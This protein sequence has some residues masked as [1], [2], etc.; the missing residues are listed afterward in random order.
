[1]KAYAITALIW[2]VIFVVF[3]PKDA[4]LWHILP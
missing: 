3:Q 2:L 4:W 1:M